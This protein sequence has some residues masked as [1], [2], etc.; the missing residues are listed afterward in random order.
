[1]HELPECYG[2]VAIGRAIDETTSHSTRLSKN[3]NQVAG[4]RESPLHITVVTVFLVQRGHDAGQQQAEYQN[5]EVDVQLQSFHHGIQPEHGEDA[6]VFVEVLHRDGAP[7]ANQQVAAMLQQRIHRHHEEAAHRTDGDQ[8]EDRQCAVGYRNHHQHDNP[9]CDADRQLPYRMFQ[10]DVFRRQYR[11]DGDAD[12]YPCGKLGGCADVVMQGDRRPGQ[13][14][15]AQRGAR[16]PEQSGDRQ[17]NLAERVFPQQPEAVPEIPGQ[18]YRVAAERFVVNG[19]IRN[20]EVENCSGDVDQHDDGDGQFG[21]AVDQRDAQ[22]LHQRGGEGGVDQNA[23]DYRTE[24]EGRDSQSFH[25][26]VRLDQLARRQV[27]GEDAVF[28]GGIGG[29]AKPDQA[30]S[31]QGMDADQ[32]G[33]ATDQLDDVADEHHATLGQRIG[34]CADEWRQHDVGNNEALL[35]Y[36]RMPGRRA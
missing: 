20:V 16:T 11:A 21:D 3:D 7:R 9:H 17:R 8:Q 22:C 19:Y 26:A 12:G 1:M 18:E 32:H 4:Y 30:V 29:G 14:H 33:E 24:H 5:D 36:R 28:G 35:Q 6:Q 15:Q 13:Y 27:F 10:L 25:P 34:K 31:K 23:A 2:A